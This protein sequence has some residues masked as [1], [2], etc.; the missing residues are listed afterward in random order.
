M[1][2]RFEL[3]SLQLFQLEM[4]FKFKSVSSEPLNISVFFTESI[5]KCN[6]QLHEKT[7]KIL[8]KDTSA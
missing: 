6:L 2:V 1:I 4:V 3:V 8:M 7:S 5:C